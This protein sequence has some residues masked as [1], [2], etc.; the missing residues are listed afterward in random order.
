[1]S[2]RGSY[3]DLFDGITCPRCKAEHGTRCIDADGQA[4]GY[5]H[6]ARGLAWVRLADERR[7]AVR[8]H[9]AHD[10]PAGPGNDAPK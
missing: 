10:K 5:A 1:M 3:S 2:T 4:T 9:E 6:S 8:T 7:A